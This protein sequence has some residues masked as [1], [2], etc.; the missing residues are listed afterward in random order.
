MFSKLHSSSPMVE[1][2]SIKRHGASSF[3]K[4]TMRVLCER[5]V[6]E[7]RELSEEKPRGQ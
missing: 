3:V 5:G 1:R 6:F 7:E 4:D 2:T